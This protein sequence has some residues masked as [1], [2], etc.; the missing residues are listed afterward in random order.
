M[1]EERPIVPWVLGLSGLVPFWMLALA[2]FSGHTLS[3]TKA[4][5]SFVL[6]T[7]AATIA[8]F[9]GGMR[10]GLAV[11]EPLGTYAW[12]DYVLS[13]I[14]QLLAW[15]ALVLADRQRL[16][17]LAILIAATGPLDLRL[18]RRGV[19]PLWFGQLRLTLSLLAGAGLLVAASAQISP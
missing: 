11:R 13:V 6:A 1:K 2:L 5:A 10:W 9:L 8:A 3:F 18:V 19:A 14:P 15:A 16:V 4:E 7:Y 12:G 17:A